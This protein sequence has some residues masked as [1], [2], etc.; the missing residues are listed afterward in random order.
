MFGAYLIVWAGQQVVFKTDFA[1]GAFTH[2][3]G[4]YQSSLQIGD[5]GSTI[6][7]V[8]VGFDSGRCLV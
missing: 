3:G 5:F 1:P 6:S 4:F 7:E 8:D 2:E